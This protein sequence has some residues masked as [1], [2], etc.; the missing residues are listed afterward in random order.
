M[1]RSQPGFFQ[2]NTVEPGNPLYCHQDFLQKVEENRNTGV[3]KRAA[4]LLQRMVVDES[5]LHYKSTRGANKG[6]RRSRLGGNRGSHFYAWWAPKGA[7]PL[8]GHPEFESAPRGAIFL[9]DI[10]HHDDHSELKPQSLEDNYLTLS[11][12]ELRTEEYVPSPWTAAQ[13]KFAQSRQHVRIVK[14]FPGSGKTSALWQA[15]DLTC[16]GSALYVTYSKDLAAL[17]RA[18]F[19]RFSPDHKNF[20]VLTYG[21]LIRELVGLE[22]EP[23]SVR[24]CRERFVQ[25]ISGFSPRILGPWAG[26]RHALYDEIHAHLIGSALPVPCG[27]FIGCAQPRLPDRTYRDIRRPYIGGAAADALLETVRTLEKREG[28]GF[29]ERFFPEL[30]LAW[31]AASEL[32]PGA[33]KRAAAA[34]LLWFDCIAVDE[35][36]DLTPLEAFV[37][38][39]LAGAVQMQQRGAVSLLIAGDEAQTVR[40]TEFEWGWFQDLIYDHLASP[41]EFRLTTNLRSPRRIASLGEAEIDEEASDQVVYCAAARGPD[42]ERL[43]TAFGEREGLAV[44]CLDERIP[45]YVPAA[46]KHKVL[47]VFEAKGLDFQAVCILD[48][49]KHLERILRE[50]ERVRRETPIVPLGKRLA[51]DQLRVAVSRPTERLYFLDV[52]AGESTRKLSMAFLSAAEPDGEIGTAIPD[53]VL[54]SLEEEALEVEE[55]VRLCEADARQFLSVKPELSWT[56]AK[57]AVAL[58]GRVG[59]RFAVSDETVRASAH[60]TLCRVA[61]CLALRGVVLS[62]ELGRPDFYEEAA[63]AALSGDKVGLVRAIDAIESVEGGR[64]GER[65]GLIADLVETLEKYREEVEAWL[66]IELSSK[67]AVWVRELEEAVAD[68]ELTARVVGVLPAAYRVFDVQRG[69]ERIAKVRAAAVESLMA[70]EKFAGALYLL[71]Q[72]PDASPKLVAR[73]YEGLKEHRK[74]AELYLDQGNRKDALR[75]FRAVP[76]IEKAIELS[77]DLEAYPAAESLQW[78]SDLR[79]TLAR[80]PANFARVATEAEKNLLQEMLET[81]LD[82]PRRKPAPRK[83]AKPR[84]RAAPKA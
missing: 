57:Q 18:H 25:Q 47:S 49:G 64:P 78:L 16:S 42:L 5:R 3:G 23:E 26:Q 56:R 62:P 81:S 76:D 46:M 60:L 68:L 1:S 11:A 58:L 39:E 77:S 82:G 67:S 79:A 12:R 34:K 32:H 73:C 14:G 43:L 38:V 61:F 48:P 22:T 52:G 80:R 15:T 8:K 66:A 55:R 37:L 4:F 30:M 28:E 72:T 59:D 2:F 6:W 54:K 19:R 51:I 27:R 24:A 69:S 63:D 31:R 44:I 45:D 10:R 17:A 71:E 7:P 40:P 33:R 13:A 35:A 50:E 20:R 84:K 9:R 65:A 41:S 74:A 29:Y 53:S 36:Q 75:N 83:T 70:A 21:G